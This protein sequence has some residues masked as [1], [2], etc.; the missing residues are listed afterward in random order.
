MLLAGKQMAG[1]KL[2][3]QQLVL[4]Q[5]GMIILFPGKGEWA[6]AWAW[7]W[8]VGLAGSAAD[9]R[10]VKQ[11]TQQVLHQEGR[12]VGGGWYVWW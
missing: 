5:V 7:A 6:W 8:V 1:V 2:G 10:C 4:H 3:T 12:V 9:G 11:G